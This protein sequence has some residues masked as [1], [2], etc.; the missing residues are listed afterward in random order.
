MPSR[1][2]EKERGISFH[3]NE[4][5]SFIRTE[6]LK[7]NCSRVAGD[8]FGGECI[9]CTLVINEPRDRKIVIGEFS[10]LST[11]CIRYQKKQRFERRIF[12]EKQRKYYFGKFGSRSKQIFSKH[13][14]FRLK[15]IAQCNTTC[16]AR[17]M[18]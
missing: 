4:I 3:K 18:S 13:F 7:I 2:G 8:V 12:N 5:S 15:I 17:Q 9:W 16:Y 10:L 14:L 1:C 6:K 11:R